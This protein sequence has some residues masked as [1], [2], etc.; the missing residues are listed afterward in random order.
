MIPLYDTARSRTFALVNWAIILLNGLVFYYEL[1]LGNA[2]LERFILTWGLNAP[3]LIARPEAAWPTV[4]TSMFIHGGWFHILSNMWV[5][6]IF[7]DN[8]EDRLGGGRYLVFYLLSGVAA[9][10]M[11]TFILPGSRAGMVDA[12]GAV[13]LASQWQSVG[14]AKVVDSGTMA[15]NTA[16][17]D[18]GTAVTRTFHVDASLRVEH[19]ELVEPFLLD[20]PA[21]VKLRED[22][23][24]KARRF[25]EPE[26]GRGRVAGFR[27]YANG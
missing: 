16:V 17:S 23:L 18:A 20:A 5:L 24:E 2:G 22:K 15:V 4:F 27:F 6:F 13:Q 10:L 26:P 7:G 21:R 3:A 9:A 14:P 19:V 1:Q 11:E 8:V 25:H 12:A